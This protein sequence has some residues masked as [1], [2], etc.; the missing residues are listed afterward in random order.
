MTLLSCDEIVRS[1][2]AL[3]FDG[4]R[5]KAHNEVDQ[6]RESSKMLSA[7]RRPRPGGTIP[8]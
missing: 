5:R 8:D 2:A 4:I 7:R 1:N 3:I 6:I